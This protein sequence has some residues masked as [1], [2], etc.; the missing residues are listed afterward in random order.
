MCEIITPELLPSVTK[1]SFASP[2]EGIE[3]T[4]AY[5]YQGNATIPDRSRFEWKRTNGQTGT[6]VVATSKTYTPVAEDVGKYLVVTKY[7]T[8]SK[9]F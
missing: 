3:I 7:I 6:V 9:R 5:T 1:F 2:V 4:P 8:A